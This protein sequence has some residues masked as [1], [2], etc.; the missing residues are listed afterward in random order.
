M[1]IEIVLC[2][3][4]DEADIFDERGD[5]ILLMWPKMFKIGSPAFKE[6]VSF[7]LVEKWF[8]IVLR[9]GH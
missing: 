2:F 6:C 1:R 8:R 5:E 3:C 4:F 7:E 9:G